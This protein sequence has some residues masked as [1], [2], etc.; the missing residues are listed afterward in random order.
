MRRLLLVR[1]A[2]LWSLGG[3][4]AVADDAGVELYE[5]KVRPVLAKHCYECHGPEKQEANLRVDSVAAM[6]RGGDQGAALVPGEPD[7]SLLVVGIRY[8]DLDFQMPPKG[9]LSGAEV[10]GIVEWIRGGAAAP[11]EDER[12]TA[13]KKPAFDLSERKKHWCF[14][15]LAAG[16]PPAVR[17]GAWP[18]GDVDR[19]VLAKL[20]AAGLPPAADADPRA[21]CRRLYLD[22]IGLPPTPEEVQEFVRSYSAASA[23]S[24]APSHAG[25][26][27]EREQ[28]IAALV[29]K[30][31]ASPGFGE[32]WARHWLDLVR[33]AETR[34]HEFDY[35]IPNAYQY[36]DYV[37]RSLNDDVPYDRFVV[38]HLAGDLLAAPRLDPRTGANRSIVGTG[39]YFLGEEVHSPVDIRQDET[40][41]VDNKIDVLSK[42][43]LGL[44][45]SCARCHD[46]KFDALSTRDYYALAGYVLSL[47][48]R[49]TAFETSAA[50]GR[51]F[52]AVKALEA[53]HERDLRTAQLELLQPMLRRAADYLLGCREVF[54]RLRKSNDA[55][56][57]AIV[58]TL[59][60]ERNLDVERL[61]AWVACC[62]EP[63]ARGGP[64]ASLLDAVVRDRLPSAAP[65][66]SEPADSRLR[67][68][69]DYARLAPGEWLVDGLTFGDRPRPVGSLRFGVSADRPIERV[70]P[71]AAA[72]A[73]P[74]WDLPRPATD[75]EPDPGRLNWRQTS[76]TLKTPTFTLATGKIRYRI[77]GSAHVYA[78][79]ASHRINN[80]PLHGGLVKHAPG[81]DV[82]RWVEHDLTAYR[83]RR[84]HLEF[85]PYDAADLKDGQSSELAV[86][87]VI[88]LGDAATPLPSQWPDD[89]NVAGAS[90]APLEQGLVAAQREGS[91]VE[92]RARHGA[93]AAAE[94]LRRAA[95]AVFLGI[96]PP[97]SA[98]S[99]LVDAMLRRPELW[100]TPSE[101]ALR[102]VEPFF[103]ARAA[104]EADLRRTS[105]TAPAA[106]DGTA[107]D[108]H[109]LIRGNHRTPGELAPRRFLEALDGPTPSA[110]VRGRLELA[111][112]LVDGRDPLPARVMVNRVWH[113]LFG[114]GIVKT[115]DNFGLMGDAPTHPELLDHLA[116]RFMAEGWS[117]KRL[118][119]EL[120]T[121]R[122]YRM[123]SVAANAAA[124]AADPDNNLYHRAN[125]KRL[126]AEVIRDSLTAVAGRLDPKPFGP[127]VEVHL[128]PFMEGRGRPSSGPL[129]GAGRRS[130]YL[131]VRRN[132]LN[133]MFQA[134]DVPTPFTTVGRRSVSNVP[135]QALSLMNGPLVV[136][137]AGSWARRSLARPAA[138]TDER[139]GRLYE[140][141]FARQA[142]ADELAT[143]REFVTS[144]SAAYGAK[145]NDP[146]VW[147]D[148]CHVLFNVKEFVFVP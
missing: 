133:P 116:A 136:D 5:K 69:V 1:I 24:R 46:H 103:T 60:A 97:T 56:R 65:P 29:D 28:A 20:E 129:D 137:L 14:Q 86:R 85:S 59:A 18:V 44:T 138:S 50:N 71:F 72:V 126:D 140:E 77:R 7:T 123:A 21:L 61:E 131:R 88:E 148:F 146:R 78:A 143:A 13:M 23:P 12:P 63:A 31:L 2:L 47:S 11:R 91:D 3:R 74:H 141:A 43:F 16:P 132:F 48:Y 67:V 135:A 45:L 98:E 125:L 58:L 66:M 57:S 144:Q 93:T 68:L 142:T 6:L 104:L 119:R 33:Y 62:D 115:V 100:S 120:A 26:S 127:S 49:Q 34:G 113:H 106:W 19:F 108:E 92:D 139:I 42:T 15:P 122:T 27:K 10:A 114:R 87:G 32:R 112:R 147:T 25:S 4:F 96:R 9:K 64:F 75:N 102:L 8:D 89:A 107:I 134:Y 79:V 128:T 53:R 17:N 121:A 36:R 82:Y 35:L 41:R 40:D 117:V 145:P 55:E 70:E 94:T 76:R 118:I 54:A 52:A 109:V 95:E 30:L 73:D 101:Q 111:E 110:P 124:D 90:M 99:H 83:G 84:V 80:G 37:I 38:E 105:H 81:D 22:L 51:V 130:I 39:F